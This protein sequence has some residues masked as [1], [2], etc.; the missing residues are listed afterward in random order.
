MLAFLLTPLGRIIGYA[1]VAVLLCGLAFGWYEIKI[2]QAKSE[3]LA[4]FNQQQLEQVVK[5]QQTLLNQMKVIQDQGQ[6]L[7]QS[8]DNLNK[9]IK[10]QADKADLTIKNSTDTQLDPLFNDVV[11]EIRGMP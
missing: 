9:S 2:N 10:D 6:A 5:D 7:Q 8:T 4:T 1:G 3:A 11:K